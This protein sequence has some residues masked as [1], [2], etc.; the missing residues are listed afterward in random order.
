MSILDA[1]REFIGHRCACQDLKAGP[2]TVDRVPHLER[3]RYATMAPDERALTLEIEHARHKREK[4]EDLAY[5]TSLVDLMKLVG[6]DSS[7]ENRRR[8]ADE[9]GWPGDP[10]DTA[11]MNTSLYPQVLEGLQIAY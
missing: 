7:L 6:L 2:E 3:E 9:V 1:I 8:L 4:N 11:A 10:S 5:K